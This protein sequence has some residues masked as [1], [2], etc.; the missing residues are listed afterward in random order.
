MSN[1]I[2]NTGNQ[3]FSL[4]P[5]NLDEAMKYAEL[6][7]KSSFVPKDYK[8]KPG[9]ILVAVQMGA[10]TGLPPIQALQNIAVI[11]GRPSVWGDAALA[12][13]QSHPK[14]EG[15]EES[16]TDND[17]K[18]VCVVKRKGES[19]YKVSFSVEDAKKAGLWGRQGPWSTYP[20][21][22]LQ[23][24]ARGFA[25]RDKFSDALKGMI[26]REEAE[27]LPRE[28]KIVREEK[29]YTS[30]SDQLTAA[31]Q[32]PIVETKPQEAVQV[33]EDVVLSQNAPSIVERML[34]RLHE[35][36]VDYDDIMK[37]VGVKFLD[38]I[39]DSHKDKLKAI[40]MKLK[41]PSNIE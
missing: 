1:E 26:T 39:N 21:R 29:T 18:A 19:D 31:L 34:D 3:T 7:A 24:R 5:R 8:G 2:A 22:M 15:I 40:G 11:N 41:P 17:T 25:L 27:D 20:K 6:L 23:M 36:G 38:D 12:I 14:Y 4:S 30:K 9:D 16:L 13:C 33:F 37:E 10:E 35:L 28:M 32:S